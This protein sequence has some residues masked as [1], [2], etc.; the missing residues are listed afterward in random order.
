MLFR[1]PDGI[2]VDKLSPMRRMMPYILRTRNESCVYFEQ[3]L[4]L[5]ETLPYLAKL[6]AQLGRS[7]TD[8]I[9]F[10]HLLLA[11]TARVFS[12]RPELNRF[13]SGG[14]IYQ[15]RH[16]ELSFAIKKERS[17]KGVRH[18]QAALHRSRKLGRHRKPDARRRHRRTKRQKEPSGP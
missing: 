14:K 5:S 15:R 13:V 11:A 7:K 10:F 3:K 18:H 8:E 9:N 4:D 16:I 2:L 17:D 6:N 1:R 12:E